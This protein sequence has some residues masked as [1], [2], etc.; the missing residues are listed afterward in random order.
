MV[1]SDL[2]A[3]VNDWGAIP[4]AM[5]DREPA[6]GVPATEVADACFSVFAADGHAARAD[7]VSKLLAGTGVRPALT[8]GADGLTAAW[9]VDDP[10]QAPLAAAALALRTHLAAHPGRIG[11]C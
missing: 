10:D 4:R 5:A 11:V 9:T 3:L 8:G 1:M 6:A 7:L 2:V